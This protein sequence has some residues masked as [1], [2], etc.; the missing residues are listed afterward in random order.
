MYNTKFLLLK[1][2]QTC[3]MVITAK[4]RARRTPLPRAESENDLL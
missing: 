4:R 1:L 3:N 2:V